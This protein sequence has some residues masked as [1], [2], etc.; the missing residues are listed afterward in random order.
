[1]NSCVPMVGDADHAMTHDHNVV[2]N[3]WY[4]YYQDDI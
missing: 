2:L 4:I 3:G 1:M